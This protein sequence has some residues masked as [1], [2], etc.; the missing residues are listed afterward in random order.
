V[1][2]GELSGIERNGQDVS[3][4]PFRSVTAG[5]VVR[6]RELAVGQIKT[7]H[8][9][10]VQETLEGCDPPPLSVRGARE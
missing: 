4:S 8:G 5:V 7:W 1:L 3:D 9:R 10:R 6:I 2:L